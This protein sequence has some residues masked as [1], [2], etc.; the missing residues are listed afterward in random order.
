[1]KATVYI[2]IPVEIEVDYS[3]A[4]PQT[5]NDP[6]CPETFELTSY[7]TAPILDAVDV[8]IDQLTD[9]EINCAGIDALEK[10]KAKYRKDLAERR[11]ECIKN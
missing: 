4:E 5:Y 7:I 1:M 11:A 8:A 3:P 10:L 6:G 2:E 9:D